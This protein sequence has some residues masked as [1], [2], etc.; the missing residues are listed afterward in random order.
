[1]ERVV[2]KNAREVDMWKKNPPIILTPAR[3]E[4]E[5]NL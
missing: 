5:K 2:I 3:E 4:D 1:L